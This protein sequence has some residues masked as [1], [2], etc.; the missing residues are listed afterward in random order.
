MKG[1]PQKSPI[2]HR[3][4]ATW[5]SKTA[6]KI[7][8]KRQDDSDT[9]RLHGSGSAA[10]SRIGRNLRM[11]LCPAHTHPSCDPMRFARPV[12]TEGEPQRRSRDAA[13]NRLAPLGRTI[14]INKRVNPIAKAKARA[15]ADSHYG[16]CFCINT[17]LG[18]LIHFTAPSTPPESG[19]P[20]TMAR[21]VMVVPSESASFQCR[22][23]VLFRSLMMACWMRSSP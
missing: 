3:Y 15:D 10:P 17:A 20:L 22:G 14:D 18:S 12:E 13:N 9:G 1:Q 7:K 6:E 16:L 21:K 11:S 19:N 2:P 4:G 8:T 5:L 23:A